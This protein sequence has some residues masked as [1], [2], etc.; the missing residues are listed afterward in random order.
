MGG[1]PVQ[2]ARPRGQGEVSLFDAESV[3]ELELPWVEPTKR[4]LTVLALDRCHA[5]S[6]WHDELVG[7]NATTVLGRLLGVPVTSR[8]IP[9][10]LRLA[11][12]ITPTLGP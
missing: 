2:P 9:T 4:A 7:S 6:S 3:P 12:R 8:G 1:R 11:L 5:V 10:M